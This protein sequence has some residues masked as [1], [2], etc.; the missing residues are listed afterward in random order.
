MTRSSRRASSSRRRTSP[1]SGQRS[2]PC[3]RWAPSRP[4]PGPTPRS[5]PGRP[6]S[7]PCTC[8]SAVLSSLKWVPFT[9]MLPALSVASVKLYG[10]SP[11]PPLSVLTAVR[12][13]VTWTA[14]TIV[15]PGLTVASVK[16][17]GNVAVTDLAAV[18][19]TAQEGEVPLQAPP[20]C[21]K[22]APLAG[23]TVSVTMVPELKLAAQLDGQLIPPELLATVPLPEPRAATVRAK[24]PGGV[25]AV[26]W[27]E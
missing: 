16:T 1:S 25:F 11:L 22:V 19:V 5:R 23:E 3:A 2:R 15:L 9:A 10:P 20:H 24:E 4:S 14:L 18:M 17:S 6:R 21:L 13:S 8:S 27:L 12:R 7:G 26:V